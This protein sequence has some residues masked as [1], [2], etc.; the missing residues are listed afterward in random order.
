M[1]L[2]LA[3]GRRVTRRFGGHVAVQ[4]V[5]VAVHPGEVLGLLG[6]N[7]AGKTTLLRMLLGLV[8]PS[9][10][11][12]RLFGVAPSLAGRRRIGYMPQGL[13]L[14]EDLTPKE[15]LMF[16]RSV[17][18]VAATPVRGEFPERA[19]GD[20]PLGVQRRV[21]FRQVL[22]HKPQLL[23]LDEPTSG[24]DPLMR[25]RLWQEVR[26]AADEGAGV[27]VSTHHMEEAEQCDRLLVLAEGRVVAEG[28]LQDILA[29]EQ[30]LVVEAADWP[31][32]M[33]RLEAAGFRPAL[34]GRSLRIEAS[35]EAEAGRVLAGL[36][37]RLSRAPATL[38]ERFVQLGSA[39][40]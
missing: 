18:G 40:P 1:A 13:G 11:E 10:G 26:A 36:G 20:L 15:N 35:A 28:D 12:V 27:L 9:E 4:E 32:A 17:F 8:P 6:A 2:A 24:V 21:A 29:G 22:Q 39:H 33:S 38:E 16:A 14:Y 19:V 37:C 7:G 5:D 23:V 34:V 3:E 30:V 31:Q 25:A